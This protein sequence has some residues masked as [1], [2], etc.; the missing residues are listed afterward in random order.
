MR[1]Q[2]KTSQESLEALQS[3]DKDRLRKIVAEFLRDCKELGTIVDEA[4]RALD[5]DPRSIAPRF[6]ELLDN[7][8]AVWLTDQSGSKIRRKT[9]L[10]CFAGVIVAREFAPVHQPVSKTFPQFGPLDPLHKDLG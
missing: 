7:G 9:R 3:G 1:Q 6:T 5:L 4:A 10:G 2:Q 8:E